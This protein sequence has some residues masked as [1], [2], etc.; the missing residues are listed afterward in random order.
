MAKVLVKLTLNDFAKWRPMFEGMAHTRTAAGISNS[1]VYQNADEPNEVLVLSE[2]G[3][4]AKAR[5]FMSSGAVRE[6]MQ[7]AGMA[8]PPEVHFIE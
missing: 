1:R 4:V 8:G 7:K 2:V 3:D 6:E 5:S